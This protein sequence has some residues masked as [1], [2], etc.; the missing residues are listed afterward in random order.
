[1]KKSL[2]SYSILVLYLGEMRNQT[3]NNSLKKGKI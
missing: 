3:I 2:D 1:M